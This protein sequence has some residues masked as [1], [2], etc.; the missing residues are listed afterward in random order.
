MHKVN[1]DANLLSADEDVKKQLITAYCVSS[2]KNE[3][4]QRISISHLKGFVISN[5]NSLYLEA[6]KSLDRETR[7][8]ALVALREELLKDYSDVK[9]DT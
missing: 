5:Y 6:N 3:D 7:I 9:G 4:L 8:T 2:T 1:T